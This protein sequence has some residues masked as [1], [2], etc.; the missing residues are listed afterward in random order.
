[1]Q[2]EVGPAPACGELEACKRIY[3]SQVTIGQGAALA[4]DAVRST[5]VQ[6]A[7]QALA[8]R[9][10]LGAVHRSFQNQADTGQGPLRSFSLNPMTMPPSETHRCTFDDR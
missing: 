6:Q 9:A 4:L 2:E 7:A 5:G 3:R 10:H 8:Q 1:M